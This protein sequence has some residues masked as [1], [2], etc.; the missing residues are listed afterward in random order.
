MDTIRLCSRFLTISENAEIIYK[1]TQFWSKE[2]ERSIY[3]NDPKLK[4][5]WPLKNSHS[6]LSPKD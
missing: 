2:H 3:S 5:G 1:T 4:I 6:N